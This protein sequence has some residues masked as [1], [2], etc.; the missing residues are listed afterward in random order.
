M[1]SLEPEMSRQKCRSNAVFTARPR[2]QRA[3]AAQ[4]RRADARSDARPS[5]AA[6]RWPA[7]HFR[8]HS[9]RLPHRDTP[10][11]GARSPA[12]LARPGRPARRVGQSWPTGAIRRRRTRR[13]PSAGASIR[14]PARRCRR[15]PPGARRARPLSRVARPV[16]PASTGIRRVD[17]G[18]AID[19]AARPPESAASGL[20]R[21][22]GQKR[23]L[24]LH[25]REHAVPRFG[26]GVPLDMPPT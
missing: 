7:A 14:S 26:V 12:E 6:A 1:T 20:S 25:V 15:R 21:D 2:H 23:T 24:D 11:R 10:T 18:I 3:P 19:R 22:R 8:I 5:R 17:R 16:A 4:P 13:R 9:P